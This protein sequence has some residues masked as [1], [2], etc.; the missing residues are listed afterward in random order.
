[1]L[2]GRIGLPVADDGTKAGAALFLHR[3]GNEDLWE[4]LGLDEY[5]R[6][7]QV[8]LGIEVEHQRRPR[9]SHHKKLT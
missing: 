4:V 2:A 8:A 7:R 9:R 5:I 1:V 3:G 6:G